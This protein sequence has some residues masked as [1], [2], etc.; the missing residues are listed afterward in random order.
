MNNKIHFIYVTI[1]GN[2]NKKTQKHM[3]VFVLIA[4]NDNML[5]ITEKDSTHS[6]GNNPYSIFYLSY[7]VW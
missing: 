7:D 5:K 1:Y 6:Y 4:K 2:I 3:C